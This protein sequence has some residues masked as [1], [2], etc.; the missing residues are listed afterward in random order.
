MPEYRIRF[1]LKEAGYSSPRIS[2][3]LRASTAHT[4]CRRQFVQPLPKLRRWTA[5]TLFA[6]PQNVADHEKWLMR[7]D[8]TKNTQISSTLQRNRYRTFFPRET[9]AQDPAQRGI[10]RTANYNKPCFGSHNG[11]QPIC[12]GT[13]FLI[14]H[15]WQPTP[16]DGNCLFCSLMA[17]R[18]QT[19]WTFR[20]SPLGFQ[21]D[22]TL[23]KGDESEARDLRRRLIENCVQ[24]GNAQEAARLQLPGSEGYDVDNLPALATM[25][26]ICIQLHSLTLE[27]P[28]KTF[29]TGQLTKIGHMLLQDSEGKVSGHFCL[30]ED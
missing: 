22:R 29:G 23:E 11:N 8:L 21:S 18:G 16:L 12:L 2:Q 6:T 15:A 17:A 1:F 5:N 26:G 10:R 4:Y 19:S 7:N 20:R 25:L 3:L 24:M 14:L 27:A 28:V 30:F 13:Q 9:L